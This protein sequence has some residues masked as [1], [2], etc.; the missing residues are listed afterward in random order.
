MQFN[1]M[2][3]ALINDPTH[4]RERASEARANA[5][6]ITDAEAKL[7]MLGIANDYER[8]AMRVAERPITSKEPQREAEA[9]KGSRPIV[10]TYDRA[11]IDA[12]SIWASKRRS[13]H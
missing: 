7:T 6:D 3:Q 11:I 12:A 1:P 4:W 8:M 2:K 5:E 10:G 13:P 9:G